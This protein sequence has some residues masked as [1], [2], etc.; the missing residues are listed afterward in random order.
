[1][2]GAVKSVY[3]KFSKYVEPLFSWLTGTLSS[4]PFLAW[5]CL[6]LGILFIVGAYFIVLFVIKKESAPKQNSAVNKEIS[7]H[8]L[9]PFGGWVS[10]FLSRKGI[11]KIGRLSLDFLNSLDFLERTLKCSDYKYKNPWILVLGGRGSG[12]TTLMHTVHTIEADWQTALK[13]KKYGDCNWFFMRNGV[14]LDVSGGLFMENE[15]V[16]ADEVGWTSLRNLLVRYRSAKPIDSILLTISAEDLYGKNRISAIQCLDRAKFMAQKLSAFQ[17]QLGLKIPVYVVITKTDIIP[18]FKEFC[19]HIPVGTKQNMFG[20]ASP[21]APEIMFSQQWVNEA[22]DFVVSKAEHIN[23][24]AFCEDFSEEAHDSLFVFPHELAKISDNL[25]IYMNQI[26]KTEQ[27]KAPLLLRGIYF[28]GDSDTLNVNAGRTEFIDV[29]LLRGTSPGDG[30]SKPDNASGDS[31]APTEQ[32]QKISDLEQ[33]KRIF[34]FGDLIANKIIPERAICVP[35]KS[36]FFAANRN[37]KIAK[38]STASFA[39]IGF[40]GIYSANKTFQTSRALISPAID[41]MYR[42]LIKT[43]QIPIL[44]LSKKNADFENS[45]R[46]LAAVMQKLSNADFFS[47]FV[48]PSWFSP[49]RSRLNKSVNIAY[50][51]VIM[52]ALYINLLLKARMLLHLEPVNIIPTTSLAQ[53]ALP[54]KSNE[55]Q[56]M[57]EFVKGL[58]ELSENVEKFNELRLSASTKLLAELVDYAFKLTL[59]TSFLKYYGQM[60]GKLRTSAFPEID[61]GVYKGLARNTFASLFQHFFNTIFI[62]SNPASLPGQL[63]RLIRQLRHI[64]SHMQPNLNYLRELE[65]DLRIVITVFEEESAG[66]VEKSPS[67]TAAIGTENIA[68]TWMDKDVF[69]PNP[70]FEEFLCALDR[71]PFFGS[72]ISQAVVDNCAV[73]MFHLKRS[74]RELTKLLTTDVR[75][76][77]SPEE[78]TRACSHGIILLGKALKI[79][80]SEPY[81]RRAS[82]HQFVACVPEGQLLYWDDKLL[83]AACE[84]CSQ[85]EEFTT[86]KVGVFPIVLQESFRLLARDGLQQN[87]MSL[88]SQSQN[89]IPSPVGTSG[90]AMEETIR[91]QTAN[92]RLVGQ[93]FLKLLEILN[94]ESVSFFYVTLRDLLLTTNYRLLDFINNLM[95]KV[96]PYHIW[97]PSFSWW[98]GKS[99]PAYPAYG[100]KDAQDLSAFLSIQGQHVINLAITLAKPVI[101]LLTSD[102]MLTVNP[103]NRALLTKWKRIVEQ[104]EA[105]QNKQP[106]NSIGTLEAFITTTLKGYTIE[107]VFQEIKLEDLQEEQGD[108]FLE[109]MQYIKK[110]LLGRAEVL[111][112][113]KSI[114]NYRTLT[115]L[116]NKNLKGKFPFSPVSTD[117]SQAIEADPEELKEFL[118]KFLEFGGSAE[119][120]LDQVYQ[121]GTIA[122]DAV[123]FLRR[124]ENI[125]E[126]LK[127]YLGENSSG[128]PTIS[129]TNEF[130]T[131]REKSIGTNFISE[132]TLKANYEA[133]VGHMDK[134]KQTKWIYGCP[135]EVSFLWPDVQGMTEHPL[136]D[137][138]QKDLTVSGT[139]AT[140]SYSGKWSI[141]RL[142]RLH[143]APRGDY[144]PMLNP[145]CIVLKFVV[146][147]S[148]TKSAVMYNSISLLG[149]STNPNLGGKVLMFPVF[150]TLAPDFSQEMSQ[151]WN[152]PVLSFGII[153]PAPIPTGVN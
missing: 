93:Q 2:L 107:N 72:E 7:P 97:D 20:W 68:P 105:Y 53:L 121:L 64:D 15:T 63:D 124:I 101:E 24:D 145:N 89:F 128:L 50:Q 81:M 21:Y 144:S 9:P 108:Y 67:E 137:A 36:K 39:A 126:V 58:T 60:Q 13:E 146:P 57:K 103:L 40:Y 148:E 109:T 99:S 84:L 69:D 135:T 62:Y 96:G 153:K 22:I 59:P 11:F 66:S 61:I 37:I 119:A 94:Y 26:F 3:T 17:D 8:K 5:I 120:I 125:A 30:T 51:N 25:L 117:P 45:V 113:Q 49:L 112:R 76:G 147:V 138:T 74:L 149:E 82:G 122:H 110:G 77:E 34:F 100:V 142:I 71:S 129:F 152:E 27:Y 4:I 75:F 35:Q 141:F 23:M 54:T 43:Q 136:P 79:L 38:I 143:R 98:D 92:V 114:N 55:F 116:F 151:Y 10:E 12:K 86:Q 134:V 52:R 29:S 102:I 140:Y 6:I 133:S 42:F 83:K 14:V 31:S 80:F 48:P 132:W 130:H 16:N 32:F 111:T 73:G 56:V 150:P 131:N 106:G 104:G 87:V 91:S 33:Y 78:S 85:Y 46:Q 118:L 90:P 1:M 88:I 19:A 18:G 47:I 123:V 41:S 127:E 44:E 28:C 65:K 115:Q 95:K 70:D 139:K